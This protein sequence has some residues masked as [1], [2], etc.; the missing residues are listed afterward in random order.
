MIELVCPQCRSVHWEI[1]ADYPGM[2]GDFVEYSDRPYTCPSCSR[3]GAGYE[4]LQKSP[5][6][7]I[8]QPHPMYPME[9]E[10]FAYW[11]RIYETNFPERARR[12]KPYL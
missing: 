10:E 8:L 3:N 6:G 4:V 11:M 5:T 1:D 9:E 7:F 12:H 2:D